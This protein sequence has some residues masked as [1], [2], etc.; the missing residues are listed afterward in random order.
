MT[1]LSRVI[2]SH[3]VPGVYPAEYSQAIRSMGIRPSSSNILVTD[4]DPGSIIAKP[5]HFEQGTAHRGS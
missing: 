5:A 4:S 3:Q 1:C 2:V